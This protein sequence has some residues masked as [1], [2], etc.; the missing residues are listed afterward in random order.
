[1]KQNRNISYIKMKVNIYKMSRMIM[2]HFL[3]LAESFKAQFSQ[4][5]TVL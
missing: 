4:L 1:L 2:I 3:R 5:L